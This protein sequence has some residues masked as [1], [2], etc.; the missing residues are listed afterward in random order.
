MARI[1]SR[2]MF[3]VAAYDKDAGNFDTVYETVSESMAFRVAR[4]LAKL[5]KNDALRNPETREPYDWIVVFHGE[6]NV[7]VTA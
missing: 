4:S 6:E 1:D 7:T 5:V 2:T 3:E